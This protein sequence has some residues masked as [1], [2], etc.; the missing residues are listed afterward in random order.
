LQPLEI[1]IKG[2]YLAELFRELRVE[3]C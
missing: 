1:P 3:L 2:K